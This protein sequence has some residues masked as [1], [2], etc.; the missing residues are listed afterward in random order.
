MTAHADP[1][2]V[3]SLSL[4]YRN[5]YEVGRHRHDWAQLI[6]ARSGLMRVEAEGRIWLA[7]PTRAIWIPAGIEHEFKIRGEVTFRTLYVAPERAG[8]VTQEI[9]A[10]EVGPLLGELILHI[11]SLEMLDPNLPGHDRLAGVLVDLVNQAQAIDLMLTLPRD[12]RARRLA[13]Q[14][15]DHPEDRR[16]LAALAP[17]AGASVRTLQR[18]FLAETGMAVDRW[19]QKARLIAST[20]ALSQGSSV[21][22]AALDCGYDSTSAFIAAF[23]RQF[24]MT[25][26]QFARHDTPL[27]SSRTSFRIHFSARGALAC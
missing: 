24:G 5:G 7:P 15:Q 11:L 26:R 20:A 22:L 10:L 25:P 18:C 2:D 6:H 16:D 12:G 13:G 8:G 19:R 3:R 1:Q 9:G 27:P 23:K 21:T 4:T 14:F 17:L